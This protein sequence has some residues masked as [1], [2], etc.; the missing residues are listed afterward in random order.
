MNYGSGVV[1]QTYTCTGC[2]TRR[3][4]KVINGKITSDVREP[5]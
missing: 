5:A 4:I 2:R 3:K 1:E